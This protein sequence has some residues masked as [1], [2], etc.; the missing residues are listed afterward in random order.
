MLGWREARGVNGLRLFVPPYG[1]YVK[2]VRIA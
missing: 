2:E 1:R